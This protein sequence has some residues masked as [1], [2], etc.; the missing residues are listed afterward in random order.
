MA[1]KIPKANVKS[2]SKEINKN[3]FLNVIKARYHSPLSSDSWLQNQYPAIPSERLDKKN[4][5]AF[6]NLE[7]FQKDIRIDEVKRLLKEKPE[8]PVVILAKINKDGKYLKPVILVESDA[9]YYPQYELFASA[10]H[11]SGFVELFHNQK[12]G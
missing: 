7:P 6:E 3:V 2:E 5:L 10:Y 9:R 11:L 1:Y 8:V 12:K 4:Y